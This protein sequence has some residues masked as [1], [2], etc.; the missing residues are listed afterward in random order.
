MKFTEEQY[1]EII[2][3][4]DSRISYASAFEEISDINL[5]INNSFGEALALANHASRKWAHD[6]FVEKEDKY[7]WETKKTDKNGKTRTLAKDESGAIYYIK[8]IL[9]QGHTRLITESEIKAW[10][11][12]SLIH[13]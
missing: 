3:R 9:K 12:L 7:L 13:I 4:W 11:Y 2:T 1:Q 10:G 8:N 5:P 6:K